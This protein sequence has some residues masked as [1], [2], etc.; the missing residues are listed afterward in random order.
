MT[1]E[2][3]KEELT[4][5]LKVIETFEKD[6][7]EDGNALHTYLI[8]LTNIGARANYLRVEYQKMFRQAKKEA[9]QRL[10]T[11]GHQKQQYWAPSLAKDY[12][13]SCCGESGYMAELAERTAAQ[14]VH[15]IDAIRTIISS[16]KSERQ[17]AGIN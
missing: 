13:D 10:T 16:L 9:Y 14:C 5:Y 12:V 8:Q 4:G 11:A 15:T 7:A 6:S 3:I 1:P 17:F 2:Q